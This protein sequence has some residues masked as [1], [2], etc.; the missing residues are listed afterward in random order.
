MNNMNQEGTIMI[1]DFARAAFPFVAMGL[2]LAFVAVFHAEKA[3][4]K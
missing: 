1:A 4:G 3:K 2:A